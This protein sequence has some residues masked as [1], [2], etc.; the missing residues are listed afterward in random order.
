MMVR[1]VRA[2]NTIGGLQ[3]FTIVVTCSCDEVWTVKES[4]VQCGLT[5][6]ELGFI[7]C[8]DVTRGR[9]MVVALIFQRP[10]EGHAFIT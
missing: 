6:H 8:S 4:L 2:V 7:H 9:T 5:S 10:T 1:A 3:E